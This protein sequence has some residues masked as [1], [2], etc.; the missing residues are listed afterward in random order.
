MD[1]RCGTDCPR[2]H[3]HTGRLARARRSVSPITSR[4]YVEPSASDSVTNTVSAAGGGAATAVAYERTG[5]APAVPFGI[6]TFTTS[7]SDG[8]GNSFTQAGGHPVSA[9]ATIVFNYTVSDGGT[10]EVTGGHP[11][12][13]KQNSL[14]ALSETHRA[15]RN[16][17]VPSTRKKMPAKLDSRI[18]QSRN[19]GSSDRTLDRR[20]DTTAVRKSRQ[21]G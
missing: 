20:R 4:V 9:N 13:W 1:V 7:V 2:L 10:L 18:C 19:R 3:L 5:V 14:R 17:L 15:P 21:H 6:Q 12:P 16:A 11:R 8:L